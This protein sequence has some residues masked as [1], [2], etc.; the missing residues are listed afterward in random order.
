MV[1]RHHTLED[2][3]VRFREHVDF[4]Y[5]L[6]PR[7]DSVDEKTLMRAR[8][9][10]REMVYTEDM[11]WKWHPCVGCGSLLCMGGQARRLWVRDEARTYLYEVVAPEMLKAALE[12]AFYDPHVQSSVLRDV[13]MIFGPSIAGKPSIEDTITRVCEDLAEAR[14]RTTARLDAY[15]E[16]LMAAAW[17]PERFRDWCLD[18]EEQRDVMGMF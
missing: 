10:V 3:L 18:V 13:R 2:D 1:P 4:L 16:D 14:V 15:R 8:T 5:A 6:Y 9:A 17:H 12:E 7:T 11:T